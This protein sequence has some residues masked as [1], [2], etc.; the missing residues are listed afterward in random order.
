MYQKQMVLK[1]NVKMFFLG[2][3][4]K[5]FPIN[6]RN[7]FNEQLMFIKKEAIEEFYKRIFT[8]KFLDKTTVENEIEKSVFEKDMSYIEAVAYFF[9]VQELDIMKSNTKK[10]LSQKILNSIKKEAIKFKLLEEDSEIAKM[11]EQDSED[12][13]KVFDLI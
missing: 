9:V 5:E 10:Y 11:F 13:S 6:L 2:T 4:T 7:E 3:L 8:L 12:P 1:E